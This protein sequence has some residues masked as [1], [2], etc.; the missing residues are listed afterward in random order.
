MPFSHL[1]SAHAS[2]VVQL[3]NQ[4]LERGCDMAWFNPSVSQSDVQAP[5]Q[6][7]MKKS[8]GCKE[9]SRRALGVAYQTAAKTLADKEYGSPQRNC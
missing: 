2:G 4:G 3:A 5:K 6:D 8:D 9:T 1:K 7:L